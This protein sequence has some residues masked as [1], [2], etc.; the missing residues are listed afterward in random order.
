MKE[1][2]RDTEGVNLILFIEH[3]C[4]C[5]IP[6]QRLAQEA[7]VTPED[8]VPADSQLQGVLPEV[9]ATL[10]LEGV[11][12]RG[13]PVDQPPDH[14]LVRGAEDSLADQEALDP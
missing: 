8:G 10:E 11:G 4:W 14:V 9:D 12:V 6:C 3:W 2:L 1:L 13:P 5:A 7:G